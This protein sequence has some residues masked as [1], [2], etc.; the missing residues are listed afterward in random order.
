MKSLNKL[1][2]E[3]LKLSKNNKFEGILEPE[4][5]E[6]PETE[7]EDYNGDKVMIIGWPFNKKGDENYRRTWKY[8]KQKH[9]WVWNDI[10]SIDYIE[11]E[12][13]WFVYA[14]SEQSPTTVDCW[15]YGPEGVQAL[16]EK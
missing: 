4:D 7:G 3:K 12:N 16:R 8:I 11:N 5:I 9:Y 13:Q 1:I 14:C 10:D 2:N 6:G 15:V